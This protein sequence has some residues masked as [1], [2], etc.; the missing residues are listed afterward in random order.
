MVQRCESNGN[1][2]ANDTDVDSNSYGETKTVAGVAAG[3]HASTTGSVASSVTGN[4]G[5]ITIAADGS[6]TYVVDTL[7]C[8]F[9]LCARPARR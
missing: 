9:K 1:V 6:Y 5:S 3:V 8:P 2:M 7:S 4:Y